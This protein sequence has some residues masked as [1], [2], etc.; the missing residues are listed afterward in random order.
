[1]AYRLV[2]AL[3][4]C[5]HVRA[6]WPHISGHK[7][8]AIRIAASSYIE[9]GFPRATGWIRTRLER[10]GP[11]GDYTVGISDIYKIKDSLEQTYAIIKEAPGCEPGKYITY[12]LAH[13]FP[14]P[15]LE[16]MN[17]AEDFIPLVGTSKVRDIKKCWAGPP[18][19]AR[20]GAR[21]A[22]EGN[23]SRRGRV[24]HRRIHLT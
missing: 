9:C 2:T 16:A 6:N 14:P 12:G 22:S 15:G 23:V 4:L 10:I 18:L 17:P 20:A 19:A 8:P 7:E 13:V 5:C 24:E 1:M 3:T 11:Y 21:S